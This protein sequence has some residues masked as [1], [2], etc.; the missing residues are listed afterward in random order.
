M[1]RSS[2]SGQ[3]GRLV[4]GQDAADLAL[5]GEALRRELGEDERVVLPHLEAASIGGDQDQG[6]DIALEALEQLFRQT[7]GTG[8]VV[9]DRTVADL[10]L[11]AAP[12][13]ANGGGTV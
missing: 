1:L 6:L 4:A 5:P 8:L 10:D 9:S 13:S 12:S 11:H 2:V 7:D 3:D